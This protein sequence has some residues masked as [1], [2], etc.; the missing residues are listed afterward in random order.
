MDVDDNDK[1]A[2]ESSTTNDPE[3]DPSAVSKTSGANTEQEAKKL[4]SADINE[5]D[6]KAA[7]ASAL[8]AAA[9]KAK[10]SWFFRS[11]ANLVVSSQYL[12]S[13]EERKIK[14]AVAQ[15]VE[16]QIKKLEI[17]L[18]HFEELETIMDRE[19]EMLEI[20]RQQLLQERQQFQLEQIK[21]S[22]LKQRQPAFGTNTV[23]TPPSTLITTNGKQQ[24]PPTTSNITSPPPP[25]PPLSSSAV[26]SAAAPAPMTVSPPLP[27]TNGNDVLM[28]SEESTDSQPSDGKSSPKFRSPCISLMF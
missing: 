10:V 27:T 4:P 17:K 21:T 22:E 7:A 13:I 1:P 18:R 20:Q 12:A 11:I 23:H 8:A 25:P 24:Q 6:L 26:A 28:Q 15:V 5:R 14:S 16:M 19:R 2:G 9:V 3:D